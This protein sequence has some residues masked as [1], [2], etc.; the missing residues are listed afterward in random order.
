MAKIQHITLTTI[1]FLLVIFS[2]ISQN[3]TNYTLSPVQY[4]AKVKQFSKAPVIDVRTPGEFANGHLENALNINISDS[5]FTE[6]ISKFDKSKPIFVYCLSGARSASAA[7]YMRN[8]GF[9][10]VYDLAGGLIK[11]RNAGLPETTGNQ[12][13]QD[14]ITMEKF[15]TLL[16]SDKIVLVDFYA[17]WC[18][19]CKKMAPSLE[20]ISKEQ[21]GKVKIIRI[22]A[23]KN[24]NLAKTLNVSA[25]P[26]LILYNNKKISWNT[27]GYKTKEEI[28][29][30]LAKA[31]NQK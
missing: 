5:K 6:S 27:T 18:Q 12:V 7:N 25:L 16:S 23:E 15:N 17:D 26:T 3:A 21:K 30:Q 1:T 8:S 9:N 19:P 20:E 2:A 22:N 4:S 31:L 11:W 29:A 13:A 10:E 24:K 14:E 28:V